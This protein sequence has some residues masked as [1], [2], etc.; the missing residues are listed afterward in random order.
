[1]GAE[2]QW[3]LQSGSQ[4]YNK[5]ETERQDRDGVISSK[6]GADWVAQWL[7]SCSLLWRPGV[8]W[9]G[10]WARPTQCLSSHAVAGIP[11]IKQRKMGMNVSSRS[12][13]LGK[14]RRIGGRCQLR[15]NCPQKKK[16]IHLHIFSENTYFAH[17]LLM[18]Y[19]LIDNLLHILGKLAFCDL[20]IVY[21]IFASL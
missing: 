5:Y 11:H 16:K 19:L 8:H 6:G 12:I 7:S 18:F 20:S 4:L 9:F 3:S 21:C 1:M 17:F 13:F 14:K 2:K 10:S 15:T